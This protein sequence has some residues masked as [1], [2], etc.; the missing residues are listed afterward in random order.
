[1][2]ESGTNNRVLAAFGRQRHRTFDLS[3]GTNRGINNRLGGLIDD[4]VIVGAD[5]DAESLMDFFVRSSG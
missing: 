3:T 1:M 4:L 5:L 2:D